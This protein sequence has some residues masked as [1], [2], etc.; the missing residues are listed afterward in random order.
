LW[1]RHAAG[2]NK[3]V[4][5]ALV[6]M[7]QPQPPFQASVWIQKSLV[8]HSRDILTATRD[9][10]DCCRIGDKFVL[11]VLADV[12]CH[13][14]LLDVGTS[15]SVFVLLLNHPIRGGQVSTLSG[16]DEQREWIV[17]PPAG[18]ERIKALFTRRQLTLDAARQFSPLATSGHSRDIVTRMKQVDVTLRQ[19]APDSWTDA[20]C[21]FV[22]ESD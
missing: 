17:G 19:M 1:E 14:T 8:P 15:G 6:E 3:E 18:I 22:V 21:Q 5:A 4:I 7:R 20:I 16:P 11:Q 13:V 2:D 9:N 10:R 12:D